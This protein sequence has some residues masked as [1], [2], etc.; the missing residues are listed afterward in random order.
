MKIPMQKP[1][2]S[3]ASFLLNRF[4]IIVH[5][6]EVVFIGQG[7]FS[8]P[9]NL[10]LLGSTSGAAGT[11]FLDFLQ[12]ADDLGGALLDGLAVG[13]HHKAA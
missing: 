8:Y 4:T 10:A 7:I 3:N 12:V 13:T 11:G 9:N 2:R 5:Y 1:C 6:F